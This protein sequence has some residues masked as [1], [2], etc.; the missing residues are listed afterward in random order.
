VIITLHIASNI[1]SNITSK[2]LNIILL[3]IQG[4]IMRENTLAI[5]SHLLAFKEHK[6]LVSRGGT[7]IEIGTESK[8]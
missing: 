1:T 6:C 7:I 3:E 2:D 5:S 4:F 8:K